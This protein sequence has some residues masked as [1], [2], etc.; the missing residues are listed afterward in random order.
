MN[1]IPYLIFIFFLISC[2]IRERSSREN[3]NDSIMEKSI[4]SVDFEFK[5]KMQYQLLK[6]F[7]NRIFRINVCPIP[8]DT[9]VFSSLYILSADP[10][11]RDT[12]YKIENNIFTNTLGS[13]ITIREDSFYG[14]R[15]EK[16]TKDMFVIYAFHDQGKSISDPIRIKWYGDENTFKVI[17]IP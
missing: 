7:G 17:L 6:E 3:K 5:P 10:N 4:K 8:E 14:Y 13:D 1:K 11:I 16:W 9:M 15:F 12:L 2:Q